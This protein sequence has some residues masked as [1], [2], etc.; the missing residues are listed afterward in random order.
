MTTSRNLEKLEKRGI[1]KRIEDEEDKRGRKIIT[2]IDPEEFVVNLNTKIEELINKI[3][4]TLENGGVTIL[5]Q[6]LSKDYTV[7]VGQ[8]KIVTKNLG[9]LAH[10]KNEGIDSDQKR[11][12]IQDLIKKIGMASGYFSNIEGNVVTNSV[13]SL[14][15]SQNTKNTENK[16]GEQKKEEDGIKN[17]N[18][19]GTYGTNIEKEN[20]EITQNDDWA[21]FKVKESFSFRKYTYQKGKIVRFPILEAGKYI[22]KGLLALPCPHDQIW[23]PNERECIPIG[24]GGSER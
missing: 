15:V 22:E 19:K 12:I 7:S 16:D 5:H 6:L 20:L 18:Q 23:D 1:I 17:D 21:Y 3:S 14:V 2:L 13:T 10:E 11:A 24:Q 4:N 8:K 9:I